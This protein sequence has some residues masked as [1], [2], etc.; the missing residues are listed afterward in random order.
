MSIYKSINGK[1]ITYN[2]SVAYVTR[3]VTSASEGISSKQYSSGSLGDSGSYWDSLHFNFYLSGSNQFTQSLGVP[4]KK[5]LYASLEVPTSD[6]HPQHKHKFYTDGTLIT[7][8]QSYFGRGIRPKSFELTDDSHG[9]DIK[10]R[11]DGYGNI[12]SSNAHHSQSSNTNISSSENYIG[13][14]FYSLGIVTLTE[15]G[16]WSGSVNYTNIA[17]NTG[18][19]SIRFDSTEMIKTTEYALKVGASEFNNTSNPSIYQRVV[20]GSGSVDFSETGSTSIQIYDFATGSKFSP[21]I[22]SIGFYDNNNDLLMVAKYP[23]PIKKL[24]KDM[25]FNI[26]L[27]M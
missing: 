12:Y 9:V 2:T 26:R 6:L 11:D 10:I 23:Q 5:Y 19:Y 20:G 17:T 13:N 15:T 18:S 14:I 1:N 3:N 16:S 8:P 4:F 22:T 25:T 7:I 21:Y 27:D 24:K